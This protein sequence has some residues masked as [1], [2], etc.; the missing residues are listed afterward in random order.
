[1]CD[2][3]VL[4]GERASTQGVNF[5]LRMNGEAYWAEEMPATERST[6][7]KRIDNIVVWFV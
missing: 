1:V 7:E 2:S 3:V 6:S 4:D 5:H